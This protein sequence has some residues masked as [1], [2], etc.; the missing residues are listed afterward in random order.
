[1][2]NKNKNSRL[3]IEKNLVSTVKVWDSML[4]LFDFSTK[5]GVIEGGGKKWYSH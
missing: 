2:K 3:E 5:Y 1:M 4:E